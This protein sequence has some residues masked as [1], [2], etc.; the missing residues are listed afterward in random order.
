M[1]GISGL[2]WRDRERP[3][4]QAEVEIMNMAQYHRGPDDH[5]IFCEDNVALGHRRLSIIDLSELGHQ[6]MLSADGQSVLTF[7]GEI[8]NFVEIREELQAKGLHF[9]SGSDSEVLLAAYST[10]GTDCVQ[11]FNGMWAFAIYDRRSKSLFLSRDRAGIK[12][13]YYMK[14]DNGFVFAS[15]VKSILAAFPALRRVN[16]AMLQYFLPSGAV[17]D[18]PETF[19]ENI[20]SL[21]PAQNLVLDLVTG[22]TRQWEYWT[23]APR[24]F[25]EKW[26]GADPVA[27][28]RGL[29]ESAVKLHMRAD[30]RVGTCLSGGLD[31]STLVSLMTDLHPEPVRTYS[32][33]YKGKEYDE[34]EYVRAVN[35]H[36][37]CEGADIRTQPD[38]DLLDS[39]ATITWHQ[40]MPSAGPGLYT[41]FNVMK[42]AS[43][44][45][46]VILDGQGGDELFA[47]YLPYYPAR[48]NDLF[49][50]GGLS[51]KA[52]AYGLMGAVF[53]HYGAQWLAGVDVDPFIR[54]ALKIAR[55]SKRLVARGIGGAE[56]PFFHPRLAASGGDGG[57]KRSF[58]S[59][60]PDSLS[61]ILY[62]HTVAQS[63]P[64]LLHY[65]DRNSMAFSIEARV[66]F[67]DYRIV[68]F[69]MGLDPAYKIRDSWT[70]WVLRKV[71]EPRLPP[72]VT[73]R[74]SKMGYPTPVA[75][76]IRT[77]KDKEAVQEL[78]FSKRFLERELVSRESVDYY[79][80]QHQEGRAD[81]S[82]LL[83]R[84]ATLELW[85]R[86]FVDRFEPRTARPVPDA[87][88]R[89]VAVAA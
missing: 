9:R 68:E 38:G 10:W 73:W 62:Q 70:K 23:V 36:L 56:P 1:C 57:I 2:V 12:P 30:V 16:Y 51:K 21:M 7:N 54:T 26:V 44:D 3:A 63:I 41:Q 45:V 81:R 22:E 8:Y 25:A 88:K 82:W 42:R 66:P 31:S 58:S 13:L 46:K 19:F 89:S 80:R 52:E 59:P 15:E 48:I 60:Y 67:L 84:Y 18:G 74:R 61:N 71:A 39:L 17:D 4:G 6:P 20:V 40:D 83:Y 47:G 37:G 79:W 34:E 77:G 78:L 49:K 50:A 32:G 5:G 87:A 29:L 27:D 85:F 55:V 53:R 76:W 14:D 33:L 75:R 65:E 11:R 43:C 28:L 24:E 69:A 35:R 64:A 86:H 72:S